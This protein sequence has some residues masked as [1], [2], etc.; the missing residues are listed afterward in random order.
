MMN[1][2]VTVERVVCWPALVSAFSLARSLGSTRAAASGL[3][4]IC[5]V[6]AVTWALVSLALLEKGVNDLSKVI[7]PDSTK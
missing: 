6:T 7:S 2:A 5:L 3:D 1:M 4:S